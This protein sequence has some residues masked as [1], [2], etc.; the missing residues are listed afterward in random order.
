MSDR[1]GFWLKFYACTS[2]SHLHNFK[3]TTESQLNTEIAREINI[4]IFTLNY[5]QFQELHRI[6]IY[7]NERRI[8]KDTEHS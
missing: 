5:T 4:T 2:R 6:I 3:Q 8:K 7:T 1:I